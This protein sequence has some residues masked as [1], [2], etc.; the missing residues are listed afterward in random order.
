MPLGRG[1]GVANNLPAN[2]ARR[3]AARAALRC[4]QNLILIKTVQS[5]IIRKDREIIDSLFG[6]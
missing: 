3:G 5:S 2:Q 1:K 6:G 4:Q